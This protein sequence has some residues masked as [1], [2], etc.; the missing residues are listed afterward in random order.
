M[1]NCKSIH[2]KID[3]IDLI[4]TR[5]IKV[6]GINLPDAFIVFYLISL[7]IIM[8]IINFLEYAKLLFCY[9]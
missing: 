6:I 1:L 5:L 4:N 7:R 3:L 8:Y 2:Q 9:Q